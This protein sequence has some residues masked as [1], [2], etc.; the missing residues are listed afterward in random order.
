MG[1]CRQLAKIAKM[2]V[3]ETDSLLGKLT[4]LR[5][6]LLTRMTKVACE[7]GQRVCSAAEES[8]EE[9]EMPLVGNDEYPPSLSNSK[10]VRTSGRKREGRYKSAT[11]I[12]SKR[13][14]LKASQ[15]RN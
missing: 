15:P 13:K 14:K 6:D 8:K 4:H 3:P 1:A 10:S 9:D 5:R 7:P 2:S 11:E 12:T